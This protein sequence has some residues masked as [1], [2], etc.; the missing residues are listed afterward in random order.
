MCYFYKC[1]WCGEEIFLGCMGDLCCN[2]KNVLGDPS[3]GK[4]DCE[5]CGEEKGVAKRSR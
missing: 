2:G 1:S 5:I 4:D 3:L